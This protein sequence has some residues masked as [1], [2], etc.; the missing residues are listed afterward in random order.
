MRTAWLM[1]LPLLSLGACQRHDAPPPT[2]ASQSDNAAASAPNGV[3][4]R[5][6]GPPPTSTPG[7]P[8]PTSPAGGQAGQPTQTATSGAGSDQQGVSGASPR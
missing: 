1:A 5:Q 4:A 8:S 6:H 3:G 7:A 2:A